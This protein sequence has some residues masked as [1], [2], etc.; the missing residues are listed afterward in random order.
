[1]VE[2]IK[3]FVMKKEEDDIVVKNKKLGII[4]SNE[5]FEVMKYKFDLSRL[6]RRNLILS[7]YGC[8]FS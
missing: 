3:Y 2:I 4:I 1:M 5:K 7:N 8:S 6:D